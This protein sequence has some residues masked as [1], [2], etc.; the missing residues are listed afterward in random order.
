MVDYQHGDAAETDWADVAIGRVAEYL[1][2]ILGFDRRAFSYPSKYQDGISTPFKGGRLQGC[3]RVGCTD[4]SLEFCV[5]AFV[6]G[7][8]LLSYR[9][10][11]GAIGILSARVGHR[12][13]LYRYMVPPYAHRVP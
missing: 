12:R 7:Q 2:A 5:I 9:I 1:S 10:T 4:A 6:S 11:D 13:F 8:A 3:C